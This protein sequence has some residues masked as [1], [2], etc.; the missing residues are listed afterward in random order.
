MVKPFITIEQQIEL[1]KSR[2]LSFQDEN[3]AKLWLTF[4][5]YYEIING[6]KAHYLENTNPE[7]YKKGTYFED[8]FALFILD[9]ELRTAVQESL[10][11]IET[12]LRSTL[13]YVIAETYGHDERIYLQRNNYKSGKL[14]SD[15]S[16]KLDRLLSK[17]NKIVNDDTQPFKHYREVHG[18]C[19]PWILLKGT[20]FG[21][22]VNFFKLQKSDIKT[23]VIAKCMGIDESSVTNDIR[24]VFSE[25]LYL[26]LAYRNR[27][28]HGG[29][30]Y[31][32]IP[33]D[34]KISYRH[35]IH[36]NL[37][38]IT[39][40]EYRNGYG[41][42]DWNALK[43]ALLLFSNSTAHAMLSENMNRI[44]TVHYHQFPN[45]FQY[46]IEEMNLLDRH[47]HFEEQPK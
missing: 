1:L 14:Y 40:A 21:N 4:Y 33:K 3:Q 13:S 23:K 47:V 20:T 25:A 12:T 43:G 38:E 39:P 41:V 45:D 29:R 6:Y 15:G 24:E 28:A 34:A 19:P 27:A 5:G 31:N 16:Y 35:Y 37:Y 44:L 9:H 32:Y 8:I 17:L 26:F 46:L 42:K 11:I 22:L 10:E 18:H 36:E 7:T 30:I 2:G